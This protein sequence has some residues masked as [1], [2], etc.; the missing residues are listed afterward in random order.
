M[1]KF[2]PFF[3]QMLQ[4]VHDS[5]RFFWGTKWVDSELVIGGD[6]PFVTRLIGVSISSMAGYFTIWVCGTRWPQH[7]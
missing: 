7:G 2:I 1:Q 5:K 6:K 3:V 4:S